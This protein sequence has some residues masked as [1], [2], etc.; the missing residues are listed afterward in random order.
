MEN[1]VQLLPVINSVSLPMNRTIT[2]T[3][4]KST[5]MSSRLVVRFQIIQVH[6]EK[7]GKSITNGI[8]P[9]MILESS[10]PISKMVKSIP[11][12]LKDWVLTFFDFN[13]RLFRQ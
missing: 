9:L 3:I 10:P 5:L 4:N 8:L 1:G 6:L 12:T 13:A 7:D 11:L 2:T